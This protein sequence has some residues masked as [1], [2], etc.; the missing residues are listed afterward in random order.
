MEPDEIERVTIHLLSRVQDMFS[1]GKI[2]VLTAADRL[3][4]IERWKEARLETA[5]L[6]RTDVTH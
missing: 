6:I 2:D 1:V 3:Y 5:G 4:H